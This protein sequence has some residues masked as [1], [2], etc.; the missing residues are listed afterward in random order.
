MQYQWNQIIAPEETI[1]KEFTISA[2]Y[3]NMVFGFMILCSIV[4]GLDVYYIGIFLFLMGLLYWFYLKKAKH[5]AFTNK[6]IVLVE[7]FLGKSITS[8]DYNQITDIEIEQS[9]FDEVGGWGTIIFNTAG[10]H[11]PVIRLPFIDNPQSIK[12][13]LDQIRDSSVTNKNEITAQNTLS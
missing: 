4:V 6:R 2:R 7:A 3:R 11:S 1:Q 9:S 12:Q 5:Y 10:T 13:N 8:V